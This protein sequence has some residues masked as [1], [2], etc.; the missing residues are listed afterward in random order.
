M[1]IEWFSAEKG[2]QQSDWLR[3]DTQKLRYILRKKRPMKETHPSTQQHKTSHWID[4]GNSLKEN[5]RCAPTQKF[6][7]SDYHVF[8]ILKY[9][10]RGQHC[11]DDK[12]VQEVVR[13]WLRDTEWITT[14]ARFLSSCNARNFVEKW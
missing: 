10:M 6:S 5:L 2:D 13:S 12:A 7:L 14:A 8:G 3:S 1:R 11:E 9:R 4:I